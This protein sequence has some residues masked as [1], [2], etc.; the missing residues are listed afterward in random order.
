M[1]TFVKVVVHKINIEKSVGFFFYAKNERA[2][3]EIR[4][5]IPFIIASRILN[6]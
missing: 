3:R 4:K 6:T 1:N 5:I 2:K